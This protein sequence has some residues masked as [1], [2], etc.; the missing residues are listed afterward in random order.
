MVIS[1]DIGLPGRGPVPYSQLH[2][3]RD[4]GLGDV[5]VSW[6][7]GHYGGVADAANSRDDK[8]I[9]H[10]I[11]EMSQGGRN[12]VAIMLCDVEGRGNGGELKAVSK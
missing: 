5:V 4:I 9:P 2:A 11:N 3:Y 1:A 10:H 7:Q 6:V 8:L 12:L